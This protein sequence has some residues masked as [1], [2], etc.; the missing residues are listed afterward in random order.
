MFLN[1]K[2]NEKEAYLLSIHVAAGETLN[3]NFMLSA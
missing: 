1:V 3:P 2:R